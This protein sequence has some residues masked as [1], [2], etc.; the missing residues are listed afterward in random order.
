[1]LNDPRAEDAYRRLANPTLLVFGDHPRF[2]DP[3]ASDALI[4]ANGHLRAATIADSG[5]LPQVERPDETATAIDAF[6][7]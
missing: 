4:A 6:L 7:A 3:A 1:V 5:D 2:S